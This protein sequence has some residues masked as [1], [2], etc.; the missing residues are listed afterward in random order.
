MAN[1]E[2]TELLDKME[3]E[4]V[5]DFSFQNA[6]ALKTGTILNNQ[7]YI[8]GIL[9]EGGFGITYL[10][11]DKFLKINVAIKEY[12]PAQFAS[13]NTLTGNNAISIIEGSRADL[14]QKGI[15]SYEYEANRLT[16]FNNLEGIVSVY[17]FFF[18]NNTAYM[19]M[20]YING[21]SIKKYL[22]QNHGRIP[23]QSVLEMM[24][25]VIKSLQIIHEAGIIH[26]DISP[27]N[28]MIDEN[29]KVTIIDFGSARYFED[30]K[31]KTIMLKRGYAPPE[32]YVKNGLQ[33]P[34]TDVYSLMATIY[35]MLTSNRL[36][37]SL[38]LIG[39]SAKIEPISKFVPNIPK[40][41]ENV[42]LKGLEVDVDNRLQTA[43]EVWKCLY[44][45]KK[46]TSPQATVGK[47]VVIFISVIGALIL[48][49]LGSMFAL[50]SGEKKATES[51]N[52]PL[53]MVDSN[54]PNIE[55]PYI[56]ERFIGA[57]PIDK[58]LITYADYGD[59]IAIKD[60]DKSITECVLPQ[61]I[62]D[63]PVIAIEGIGT[64]LTALLVPDNVIE[65]KDMAFR[66]CVYLEY[67]FIP[68]S[69][70]VISKEAFT[71]CYSLNEIEVDPGNPKFYFENNSLKSIDGS[72]IFEC[73]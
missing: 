40:Q 57:Y 5:E 4:I 16:Q 52:S 25:P 41:V 18:E 24:K 68:E 20:E 63:K 62:D 69:V 8:K 38:S 27:D 66:N 55:E 15:E 51:E 35:F 72:I 53:D 36:P 14:F 31:S 67:L 33:G 26:R 32:Q 48:V 60:V 71:N 19:V 11:Y 7:Y 46:L 29:N 30:E 45:G 6:R 21:I 37:E 44:D 59:G 49:G 54:S 58:S 22:L 70:E 12:F 10:G 50:K 56:P 64:N 3:A 61:E 1:L 47:I 28:I 39:G 17:N 43:E 73:K 34:W 65:I 2:K 23:W 13:R 42:I 9:G